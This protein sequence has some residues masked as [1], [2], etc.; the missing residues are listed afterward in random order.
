MELKVNTESLR[1]E[2]YIEI[3]KC[4]W[5]ILVITKIIEGVTRPSEV[6]RAIPGLSTKVLNERIKKLELKGIIRRKSFTGYPLHVEYVLSVQGKR[7]RPLIGELKRMGLPLD[8]V[9]EVINCK[10]MVSILSL[11]SKGEARTNR[12][13]RSL[14]GISNKVLSDR[15][16]KLEKMGFISRMVIDSN[17]PGVFYSLTKRGNGFINFLKNKVIP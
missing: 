7:L 10:W 1:E 15:L 12:I 8:D 14:A 9:S 13:K 16:R 17:P 4:K 5:T 3:L 11:L 2:S 6:K